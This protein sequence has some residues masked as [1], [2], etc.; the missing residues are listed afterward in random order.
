MND[1]IKQ[2]RLAHSEI[3][4]PDAGLQTM[5]PFPSLYASDFLVYLES[6]NTAPEVARFVRDI[7]REMEWVY[8][9]WQ[10]AQHDGDPKRFMASLL[11]GVN[12]G[13]EANAYYEPI[14]KYLVDYASANGINTTTDQGSSP[15]LEALGKPVI[16][17]SAPEIIT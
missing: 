3:D 10:K 11:N 17:P 1:Q 8:G 4:V 16:P 15:W 2:W 12:G 7:A 13:G 5:A 9:C 14:R 6:Q